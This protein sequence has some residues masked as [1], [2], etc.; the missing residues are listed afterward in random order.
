MAGIVL[1]VLVACALL[2]G[3]CLGLW[4]RRKKQT[5]GDKADQQE[6]DAESNDVVVAI[7]EEDCEKALDDKPNEGIAANPEP[8]KMVTVL[9]EKVYPDGTRK[10]VF[11]KVANESN[12]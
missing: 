6:P 3:L 5:N 1:G 9:T 12:F 2:A 4:Q 7:Q 10:E 11:K 8:K